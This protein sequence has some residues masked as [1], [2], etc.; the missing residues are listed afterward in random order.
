VRTKVV[1]VWAACGFAV[2]GAARAS[3]AALVDLGEPFKADRDTIALYHMDDVASGEV[4]D[5]VGGGKPGKPV[6]ATEAGGKFG[7]AMNGDGTKSWVD[8]ADLPKTEGLK[9]LTG[10]CW[11]KFADRAWADLVCRPNQF[12]I[13]VQ[14]TL[15]AYF[16]IDGN[17]RIVKGTKAVPVG[18]WTH[19]AIT[20]DQATK[21]VS[22]YVD[23]QLDVA[24]EPEGITDAKLGSGAGNMRLGGHTWEQNPMMLNGQLDEVRISSVARQYQTSPAPREKPA[25]VGSPAVPVQDNVAAAAQVLKPWATNT[26]ATDAAQSQVQE[27]TQG[28]LKYTVSQGGTMD[29]RSCRT[30]MGCGIA[31]EGAFYQTWE[32]NRSVRMENVGET[33]VV[34]P[35]ISN[36]RN[37]FQTVDAIANSAL[38]PGM[39]DAEKAFAIWFQEIQYRH[40]APGDNNELGDPVK[41]FNIYGYNTCGNDSICMGTLWKAVGLKAAPARALGHCISQAFYDNAWHFLDGDMHCVYLLRDN[42]TVASEQ[43]IVRDHDLVKRTHS[44]GILFP[45][46]WW[47]GQGMPAMYFY[48]GEVTGQ[49]SGKADTTMNMVLRPGEALVWRWGQVTPVKYH[50]ALQTVPTYEK[51]PYVICNGLWEYRPDFTKETWRKGAKVENV[52]AGLQGLTAEEGKTGTIVWTM[53]SPYVFVGG[54]LE[55]EGTGAKFFMSQDGKTWRPAGNNLDGFFSIVGP[56]CYGYQ[57]KC[58]LEAGA[59]LKKMAII[60]DVQMA[61][62]ALPEMV[63]G[64]NVFTYTDQTPGERKVRVTHNWVERSTSKPPMAPPAAVYPPDGGDSNGTDIV[65]Q[66]TAPEVPDGGRI[67]DYQ[68]ELSRRPD[69]KLPLSMDFYKLISRTGDASVVRDKDGNI[70]SA[71]VKSQ[72][73]LPLPGLLTPDQT[74]YWHVRAMNDKGIWGAWTKTWSFTARGVACPVEVTV[75]YDQAKGLG[76]LKWK[77]NPAGKR[78]AKYRVYGSD[79][80]GFTISDQRFQSTVGV[81]KAEM[82]AWNPWFPANFIAETT[83]TELAVLGCEVNLPAANKTYYRVV[84]VDE[85]GKRSGPSDYATGPRPVIYS[86]PEVAAKVGAEYNYRVCANRSL[87]DLSARMKG[88]E[89]VSGY[90]DIEKPKF[91]LSEGPKWLKIDAATGLLSGTPDAPG[92]FQVVVSVTLERPVQKVDEAALKWGNLKVNSTSIE[93]LGPATQKFVIEVG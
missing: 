6:Q 18:R 8:F 87:G 59:Q 42:Q 5:A 13:R 28:L 7:Q 11:V 52:T 82:A 92:R 60:N 71:K 24:Q 86:K 16:W 79:E 56:A 10:E 25:G 50:G 69:M 48:I 76:T 27:I 53:S 38:A 80:K 54:R 51:V 84:A 14:G 63:V 36:G 9:Q 40:H 77:A 47:Q 46:T 58:Q 37:N 70:A 32:S 72:Y 45:D 21:M 31:R 57:L 78:P 33:D 55:T 73:T 43:D 3:V 19:L 64:E 65:F 15:N 44:Q 29:G 26:E 62:L 30:P 89:Q 91:A 85:Q 81:T 2:L 67:A 34:N 23:G 83:A 4:K 12:M 66:W 20:W 93:T 75:D 22:I 17:W 74:Y 88:N 35:W 1:V 68:F 41:V 39:T 61:P 49:R 90:F